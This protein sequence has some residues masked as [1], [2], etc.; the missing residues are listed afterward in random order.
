MMTR[1]VDG[2]PRCSRGTRRAARSRSGS[3]RAASAGTS[4]S[5]RRRADAD[6]SGLFTVLRDG[7]PVAIAR[8][9]ANAAACALVDS[10][11]AIDDARAVLARAGF[12]P[13]A[14]IGASVGGGS[15]NDAMLT[16]RE[17]TPDEARLWQDHAVVGSAEPVVVLMLG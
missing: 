4:A 7:V 6:R 2:G 17:A 16:A 15:G 13:G 11:L 5:A 3:F 1:R 10:A 9:A 8:A 14:V 12:S